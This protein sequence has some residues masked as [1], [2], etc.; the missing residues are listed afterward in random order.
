MTP[1]ILTIKKNKYILENVIKWLKMRGLDEEKDIIDDIPLLLIDDEC[2]NA[3]VNTKPLKKR[4][5]NNNSEI[6][7]TA[8]NRCIKNF[9]FIWTKGYVGYT[10]TPYANM[11][12]PRDNAEQEQIA[13]DLFPSNFIIQLDAPSN[14]IGPKEIFG[15]KEIRNRTKGVWCI[16]LLRTDIV[17]EDY[18]SFIEDGHKADYFIVSGLPDSLK[19]AIL[20]F[21]L[22]CA[23]KLERN[24]TKEHSSMLIHVTRFVDVQRQVFELVDEYLTNLRSRIL[25]G[26]RG[27]VYELNEL[28]EKEFEIVSVEMEKTG[29]G[30]RHSFEDIKKHLVPV[31][32]KIGVPL[33]IN[34]EAGDVLEYDQASKKGRGLT[35]IA[36]GGDK[37]SRGL[38]LEGLTISY[39]LR[40]SRMYD[41]LL[42]M[43]RWF[44]YKDGYLDLC[45]IYTTGELARWYSHIASVNVELESEFKSM[46]A[47]KL[48]PDKYGMKV[49][50]HS[51]L[52]E[53]TSLNKRRSGSKRKITFSDSLAKLTY[54]RSMKKY[55]N[56]MRY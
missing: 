32:E 9:K 19:Q 25:N 54:V 24:Q 34:G 18:D 36:I 3:S 7:A 45:R 11:L 51:G 14:Y 56:K 50:S 6:D 17:D 23:A 46:A 28:W 16:S 29:Y 5:G 33:Q 15:L 43:G 42:Q 2:D 37:L 47:D 8:I 39:Y 31:I 20:S 27:I 49:R 44:G 4:H 35:V 40:S 52:L 12:I 22:S 30:L 53:V 10:A 55:L 26:D 13:K 38:T 1:I 21:I 48:E 41:T